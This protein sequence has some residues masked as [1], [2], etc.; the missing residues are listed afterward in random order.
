MESTTHRLEEIAAQLAGRLDGSRLQGVLAGGLCAGIGTG[1]PA[2]A[3]LLGALEVEGVGDPQAQRE[4]LLALEIVA[5]ELRDPSLAFAPILPQDEE[6][7]ALR[8]LALG[9]WCDAFIE[10]FSACLDASGE[11]ELSESTREILGDIGSIA[12]GLDPES[13]AE[14]AEDDERDFWQIAEFVRIAAISIFAERAAPPP[15]SLH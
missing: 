13:L 3:L 15:E 4:L 8:A 1:R 11:S 5:E 2:A 12:A 10:G 9:E 14:G 6:S 7:L